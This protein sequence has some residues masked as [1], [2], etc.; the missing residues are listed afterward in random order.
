[1]GQAPPGGYPSAQSVG[2][3]LNLNFK[4]GSGPIA[5]DVSGNGYNC[6]LQQ[7]AGRTPTWTT[8]GL[9]MA[10][11]QG[12]DLPPAVNNLQTWCFSFYVP[13]VPATTDIPGSYPGLL[14]SNWGDGT[15]GLNL[16]T[17]Y[18]GSQTEQFYTD[19]YAPVIF[20]ATATPLNPSYGWAVTAT[21]TTMVGSNRLCYVLGTPGVSL[22]H[23]YLNGAETSYA[24]RNASAGLQT[25]SFFSLASAYVAHWTNSGNVTFFHV[26]GFTQALTPAI[27]QLTDQYLLQD[28]ESRGAP[29]LPPPA[30]GSEP[31]VL[32]D[33]D[34]ITVGLG[35]SDP[36][37]VW[38]SNLAL[39]NQSSYQQQLFAV[40]GATALALE[41]SEPLR[42]SPQCQD[43]SRFTGVIV[44]DGTNDLKFFAGAGPQMVA[45]NVLAQVRQLAN[46]GC[47]VFL[48]TLISRGGTAGDGGV[49]ETERDQVNQLL[50]SNGKQFGAKG[51]VD[52]AANPYLGATGAYANPL[53]GCF[54]Q[55]QTHATD[56][57]Q[58]SLAAAAS[59]SLSYYYGSTAANP[60]IYTTSN[61][62]LSSDRYV[63]AT[64]CTSTC[65]FTLPDGT[66]PSNE[67]YTIVTG[68]VPISVQGQ[69]LYG[70]TQTVNGSSEAVTLPANT[71]VSLLITPSAQASSGIQWTMSGPLSSASI[72]IPSPA[73]ELRLSR[74]G[75]RKDEYK[76]F[77][78]SL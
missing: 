40:T 73:L 78:M 51:F 52:M 18:S 53:F 70:Y 74:V 62:L 75:T 59:N 66:G 42:V 57:C 72:G 23:V 29:G 47:Q 77:R 32:F 36:A 34:S 43:K 76:S 17:M 2:L 20:S 37:S 45:S 41:A 9:S 33:G 12:C 65:S 19:I 49:F 60:S 24:V 61:R 38:T 6:T 15:S 71:T 28:M 8:A 54:Q 1:M 64:G 7:T 44:W 48:A 22:D 30:V 4:D 69:T 25:S 26:M 5:H 13:P 21:N 58:P 10:T 35:L 63:D 46:A 67:V 16:M 68:S 39:A 11:G 31:Q 56:A 27:I 55:D 3:A 14:F 50:R